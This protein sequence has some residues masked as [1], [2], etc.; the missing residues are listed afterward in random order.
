MD[1]QK[2]L[3]KFLTAE[4]E[5]EVTQIILD[6]G[7][8]VPKDW[9]PYGDLEKNYSVI[10]NQASTAEG[11]LGEKVTN[12]ID[13]LF[14]RKCYEA[15][16]NPKGKDAPKSVQEALKLFYGVLDGDPKNMTKEQEKEIIKDL[17]IMATT[18]DCKTWGQLAKDEKE[19]NIIIYDG[20]EGQSPNRLPETILSLLKGNK[21]GIPFTQGN[22]NQG[23]SGA[24]RYCGTKGYSLVVSKRHPKIVELFPNEDDSTEGEWGWTIIREELRP[25]DNDPVYTFY[26]PNGKIPS[27]KAESLP[28]KAKILKGK[29][30]QEYLDFNYSS[31]AGIP[32]TEHVQYGTAIK[33][34][35]YQLKHKGPLLSHFKYDLSK[36][37]YDTFLP[38]NLVDCRKNKFNNDGL[39]R[40]LKKILEDDLNSP[41]DRRL[42][43]K[44]FP[45][46]PYTFNIGEQEVKVTVYGLNKRDNGKKDEKAL[47]DETQPILLTLGQQIQGTM[48]ARILTSAGLGIVKKSLLTVIE[49]PNISASFKKDLFMTD[50]ERLIDKEP[51]KMIMNQ[52]KAY[53]QNEQKLLDFKEE[54]MKQNLNSNTD[55]NSENIRSVMEN[56]VNKNPDI[57]NKLALGSLLAGPQGTQ[58]T[59]TGTGSKKKK[60]KKGEPKEPKEVIL[61]DDP[62]FFTPILSMEDGG[63]E[64]NVF[65]N[66]P[67]RISFR[68]DAP[69]DF[70]ERNDKKGKLLVKSN[71]K[72]IQESYGFSMTQ[73]KFSVDFNKSLT[74]KKGVIELLIKIT[75]DEIKFDNEYTIKVIVEKPKVED[76]GTG[77][78]GEGS[79]GLPPFELITLAHGIDGVTEETAVLL[80]LSESGEKYYINV[81][82][83]YLKEK[84]EDTTSD[85]EAE[86]Y[87]QVFIFSSLLNAIA[88]KNFEEARKK[89]GKENGDIDIAEQVSYAT[90]AMARTLFLME[91][92]SFNMKQSIVA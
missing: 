73:G 9:L 5:K 31:S 92:L 51:K 17:S 13:S 58:G 74:S 2:L 83:K 68:T 27:F 72:V 21:Q 49:F 37:I 75:C 63:F 64:K 53:Y 39:F 86:Y 8:D 18:K 61:K 88:T 76:K 57:L 35:N 44:D 55:Y 54:R 79:V 47:L 40:G 29:E 36:C 71:G 1:Y 7:M 48:N 20:G 11:S 82:N 81:D 59:G 91:Q 22:F 6:E 28:L 14:T 42:I 30:A 84:L 90:S 87:K 50:R 3:L 19:L 45:L 70:F 26:A 32:Y 41:E 33:L 12:A 4:L 23:G 78:K 69:L 25:G 46:E 65:Q 15:E 10:G 34:Y 56:W 85:A 24:L 62:T 77:G 67:F 89:D 38:V 60:K 43:H 16:I 80:D 52:L 66:K